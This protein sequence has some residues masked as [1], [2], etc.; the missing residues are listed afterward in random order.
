[1]SISVTAKLNRAAKEVPNQKGSTFFVN[2]GKKEYSHKKKE[3]EWVNYSAAL[4]AGTNQVEFYRNNLCEGSVISVSG[5]GVLPQYWGDNNDKLT[6]DILD[7]KLEFSF[8]GESA[9]QQ[10]TQSN[11][12]KL[13]QTQANSSSGFDDFSDEIPF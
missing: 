11:S 9:P 13:D 7:S 1:M 4:F 2:L 12:T 6:L 5:S 10:Q 3:A 8:T